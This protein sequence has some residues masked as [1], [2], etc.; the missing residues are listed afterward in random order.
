MMPRSSG[1]SFE[2]V[3]AGKKNNFDV[4]IILSSIFNS[5]GDNQHYPSKAEL[6]YHHAL[7]DDL[8]FKDGI[9]YFTWHPSIALAK[10]LNW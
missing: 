2:V 4:T 9:H 5:G 1:W 6:T 7:A 3:F 8:L 10:V